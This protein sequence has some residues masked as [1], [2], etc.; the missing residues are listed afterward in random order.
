MFVAD[1]FAVSCS[2]IEYT[3][4]LCDMSSDPCYRSRSSTDR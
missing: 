4:F 2:M 1:D 3:G